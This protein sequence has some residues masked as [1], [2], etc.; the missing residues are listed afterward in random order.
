MCIFIV[1]LCYLVVIIGKKAKNRNRYNQVPHLTQDT[2][3]QGD[4]TTIKHH[5]QESQEVS[6]YPAGESWYDI[7]IVFIGQIHL[8]RSVMKTFCNYCDELKY[9]NI[10]SVRQAS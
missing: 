1:Y 3:W 10:T 4:K 9:K 7:W 8:L 2:T 5:I 6:P